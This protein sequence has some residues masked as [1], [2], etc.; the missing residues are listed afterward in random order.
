MLRR[1]GRDLLSDWSDGSRR[2]VSVSSLRKSCPCA[3]CREKSTAAPASVG[4]L[5]VLTA[6]EAKPLAIEGMQPVGN[7]AY[8][9]DF[10]DGH[11]SGLYPVELIF[12]L[13]TPVTTDA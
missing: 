3:L 6:A 9:I 11:H 12:E 13:S 4:Q 5:P 8:R 10:S 1:S 7:Y 2:L